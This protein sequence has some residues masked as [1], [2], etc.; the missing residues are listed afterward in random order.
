MIERIGP[1]KTFF[2]LVLIGLIAVLAAAN[3]LVLEPKSVETKQ[4]L[5]MTIG[6]SSVLRSE[7]EKMR[8]DLVEAEKQKAFYDAIT[9]MGFFNDQDRVIARQRF[10][11]MQKMSKIISARYEI[12]PATILEDANSERTGFVIMESAITVSLA[13]VDDLDV[14][15]F[16]YFLNYGFPG[17]ITI[18]SLNIVRKAEVTPSLLKQIGTGVSPEVVSARLELQ[19]RTMAR[20]DAIDAQSMFS[21]SVG[22]GAN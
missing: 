5:D 14:Y 9:R 10:E 18:E 13:A 3:Y 15:R 1:R 8:A 17:H 19:W 12:R 7:V 6:E 16:I 11:T 20:K 4:T 2:I 21:A 22:T